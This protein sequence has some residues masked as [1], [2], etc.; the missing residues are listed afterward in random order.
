MATTIAEMTEARQTCR[1]V[2]PICRVNTLCPICLRVS[3]ISPWV[4]Y[5]LQTEITKSQTLQFL[6]YEHDPPFLSRC[7]PELCQSEP[8]NTHGQMIVN[9]NARFHEVFF[10]FGCSLFPTSFF[11]RDVGGNVVFE[12]S[13]SNCMNRLNKHHTFDV[14]V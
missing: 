13:R 2:D 14:M 12:S 9:R 11:W 8:R 4:H 7:I 6:V 3:Y 1:Y 10:D 5:N